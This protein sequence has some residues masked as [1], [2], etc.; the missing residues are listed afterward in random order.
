[1]RPTV[2]GMTTTAALDPFAATVRGIDEPDP[3]RA[4]LRS[5]GPLVRAQ[6]PAGGPV[7]IVTDDALARA[8]LDRPARRQGP[9][10]GAGGVGPAR[11]RA[12]TSG[13]R[14]AVADDV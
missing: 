5:A 8:V 13:R 12:R 2:G 1:M 6:A 3:V 10:V 11:G 4:A 9:R 7:W 14:R